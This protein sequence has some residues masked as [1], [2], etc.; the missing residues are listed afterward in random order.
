MNV[1]YFGADDSWANLQQIGFRRRNTCILKALAE[2]ELVDKLFIVRKVTRKEF[3]KWL[4]LKSETNKKI[5]DICYASFLPQG[6]C[7]KTGLLNLNK[8]IN[9]FILK[10]IT[11]ENSEKNLLWAYWPNGFFIADDSGLK[12][13]LIFDTDHNIIDDPNIRSNEIEARKN[14]LL[15]AGN[16]SEFILSSAV[17]MI[18]W[19]HEQGFANT[20]RLRNGVDA[21]RFIKSRDSKEKKPFTVGYCGILSKWID[22]NLFQKIIQRNP[23]WRFQIIGTPYLNEDWQLLKQYRNVELLGSK[24][25]DEVAK[26]I[27]GFDAA[28]NL[29]RKHPALDVDSMK[30][31]E[32]IAAGVPVVSTRFHSGLEEDFNG[33]IHEAD[34]IEELEA[35]LKCIEQ[36]KPDREMDIKHFLNHSSW[37]FRIDNFIKYVDMRN[38]N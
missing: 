11:G 37:N 7:K 9:A 26:I 25:A 29:Y 18:K 13:K 30:L 34:S 21:S 36:Q 2:N 32:Y 19:Y 35:A 10:R 3:L 38:E 8:K 1:F 17:S 5:N 22:Y 33:L 4:K 27:P 20:Y 15:Q 31:Y 12:G 14:L 24:S 6:F 23:Q 28:I 16:K